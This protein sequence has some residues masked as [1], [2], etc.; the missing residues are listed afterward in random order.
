MSTSSLPS[1][2]APSFSQTPSYSAEPHQHE[3]RIALADR[4]RPRPTGDFVKK[5]TN[6][7]ARLRLTAQENNIELPT[8]GAQSCVEGVVELSK[9]EHITSVEVKIEGRLRLKEIAE[10]GTTSAKLCLDTVVLWRRDS[11]HSMCPS[12]LPFSLDLPPMFTYEDKTYPLPPTFDVKLSGLPGFTASIDYSVSATILKQQFPTPS[13]LPL[14]KSNLLSISTTVAT[15]F[16]YHPR[17]RPATPLPPP[18]IPSRHGFI[19]APNWTCHT[20]EIRAK[21]KGGQNVITKLYLPTSRIFCISQQIPFHVTF[22]SS[23]RSLTAFLPYCPTVGFIR[24]KQATRMQLMRQSTVDVRNAMV[25]GAK[26]DIWR[27]DCI[28]EGTFRH[29]GDGPTWT[30]FSGEITI[31]ESVK[32][33][34]FKA[35]GLS[36]KDCVLLSMTPPDPRR[37]PFN[38]LRQVIPVRLT[39]DAWTADGTGV[40]VIHRR[41]G[42]QYSVASLLDDTEDT[43]HS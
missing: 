40:G 29:A 4:S 15:P 34:G 25:S 13:R 28:G 3:Q 43:V 41:T 5:S 12:N 21:G 39:T 36:V 30:L 8:Y 27:V 19:E 6:G 32:V 35:S 23:G 38:E 11:S 42:S 1:Y 9:V 2:V 22:E 16:I 26:T 20:S 24:P 31:S 37:S 33:S 18:L 17:T 10:G 14:V 7:D